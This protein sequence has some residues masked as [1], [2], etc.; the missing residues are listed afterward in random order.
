MTKQSG[1]ILNQLADQGFFKPKI[2]EYLDLIRKHQPIRVFHEELN[3]YIELD[4]EDG[5]D[6]VKEW[7]KN[8]NFS[9]NERRSF[10]YQVENLESDL[11]NKEKLESEAASALSSLKTKAREDLPPAVQ[12][13]IPTSQ[14]KANLIV[15][16]QIKDLENRLFDTMITFYY[17]SPLLKDIGNTDLRTRAATILSAYPQITAYY[18]P[19]NE[20]SGRTHLS[21]A[22]NQIQMILSRAIPELAPLYYTL[23]SDDMEAKT[24]KTL[25]D[26]KTELHKRYPGHSEAEIDLKTLNSDISHFYQLTR[27]GSTLT[28]IADIINALPPSYLTQDVRGLDQTIRKIVV[29]AATGTHVSGSELLLQLVREGVIP[30]DAADKLAFLAPSLELAQINIRSELGGYTLLDHTNTREKWSANLAASTGLNP[31]TFW[32][33]DKEIEEATKHLLGLPDYKGVTTLQEAMD[34]EIA[35][36]NPNFKIY[37][38]L[39][40]LK[41]QS[42]QRKQYHQISSD[43]TLFFLQ[44]QISKVGYN[45]QVIKEPYD[46]ASRRFWSA[47]D[48][49]DEVIHYPQRKLADFWEDLVDGRKK[50]L[51]LSAVIDFKTKTGKIIHIPLLNLPGFFLD[52]F[53]VFRKYLAT[54]VFKWSW[55]LAKQGGIFSPL[56]HVANY[57]FGFIQH[58]GDFR[59]T[60][61]YFSRKAMGNFLDWGAKQLKFESFAAMK[62]WG[63]EG[64][65]KIGNKITG[66]LLGKATAYLTSLGLSVEGIGIFLTAAMLAIDVVKGITGFFKKLFNDE[67]FRNNFFNWAP[68]IGIF[69][70][71]VG[72]FLAGIPAA[73]AFGF[74]GLISFFGLALS[75]IALFFVQGIIWAG[76]TVLAVMFIFQI[77][78][79][80]I[81][82]DSGPNEFVASIICN[83]N[84]EGSTTTTSPAASAAMCIVETLQGCNLSPLLGSMLDGSAWKCALAAITN[85]QVAVEIYNSAQHNTY[86]QC[87]GFIAATAAWIGKPIPQ[88]NACSYVNNAPSGYRYYSNTADMQV[89]DFFVI[90]S[91][92]CVDSSPGHVGV[93]CGVAGTVITACDANYGVAGGVRGDGQFARSQITGF[94]R[95]L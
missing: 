56:K 35:K 14:Q 85:P 5:W 30:S 92:N 84:S 22:T 17:N 2:R 39:S 47:F 40:L 48:N 44:D 8:N 38:Q 61:F 93:V 54:N 51:G 82:L 68:A 65:L 12:Q 6:F 20:T 70:G 13:A 1:I 53:I 19:L 27:I 76:A 29:R 9:I 32:L 73:I 80:T 78:N 72:T 23:R 66:G 15:R 52:Q 3:R 94:M 7:A 86:F 95:P 41:D 43:N 24:E 60:N 63:G 88:I 79:T 33:K 21:Q 71:G 42:T 59:S 55:G 18:N 36:P 28:D 91:S 10:K 67:K 57:S 46:K 26:A 37:N 4:Y 62:K 31:S 11:S 58:D 69:L 50:F 49:I 90:G 34:L 83:Q 89:G 87:V 81:H 16:K 77:F 74:T 25:I 75:G 64:L 45:L